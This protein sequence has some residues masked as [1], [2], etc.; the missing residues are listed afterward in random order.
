M[1]L[2]QYLRDPAHRLRFLAGCGLLMGVIFLMKVEITTAAGAALAVGVTASL[3]SRRATFKTWLASLSLIFVSTALPLLVAFLLLKVHLP[4]RQAL[5][6]MLGS[7]KYL[8]ERQITSNTYYRSLIGTDRL[9]ENLQMMLCVLAC[10]LLALLPPAIVALVVSPRGKSIERSQLIV[11]AGIYIAVIFG[12]FFDANTG[13]AS[14][15]KPLNLAAVVAVSAF[16]I[17]GIR[18]KFQPSPR[19][20]LQLAFSV[21]SLALLAKTFFAISISHYGFVLTAPVFALTVMSLVCW[22]PR[23]IDSRSGTGNI[24]RAAAIIALACF[25]FRH[26]LVYETNINARPV[27]AI[28]VGADAF[29]AARNGYLINSAL[30]SIRGLPP[31]DTVATI[32]EG[33]MLNYQTRRVNPTGE[34]LLLPGEVAM[35]GEPRVL[36]Q[37]TLHPPDWIVLLPT[38]LKTFGSAGFGVDYAHSVAQ[39]I[40]DNYDQTDGL[41]LPD[42]TPSAIHL[43]R[44]DPGHQKTGKSAAIPLDL[45]RSESEG[46]LI[47]H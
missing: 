36:R 23:W 28:G 43:L 44:H 8:G 20:I 32:P 13:W 2:W 47:R 3:I 27:Q 31:G 46:E 39:F 12:L 34:L 15:A 5:E 6:G 4:T 42:G 41:L 18:N 7:W 10:E 14:I 26:L 9:R 24:L 21:F 45:L 17:A 19:L 30:N 11:G 1:L 35:F 29:D 33:V 16:L 38:N 22:I 37:F 40:V 25:A